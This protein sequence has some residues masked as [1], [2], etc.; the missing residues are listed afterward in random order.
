MRNN[1]I[2]TTG[3]NFVGLRFRLQIP[4]KFGAIICR[5]G[6]SY[7]FLCIFF[8]VGQVKVF[9]IRVLDFRDDTPPDYQLNSSPSSK[10]N[11]EPLLTLLGTS[12]PLCR[13]LEPSSQGEEEEEG[14]C[15]FKEHLVIPSSV[16]LNQHNFI[17]QRSK[18]P[19]WQ[20]CLERV[21]L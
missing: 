3:C 9:T 17:C 4:S 8:R 18:S 1:I 6:S 13:R 19:L 15:Q 2:S 5:P 14:N 11:L 20:R 10:I 12:P 16:K 7:S 21:Q